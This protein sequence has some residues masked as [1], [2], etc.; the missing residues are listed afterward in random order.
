MSLS[1]SC[2]CGAGG[3]GF[4]AAITIEPDVYNEVQQ[5]IS[6]NPVSN[7]CMVLIYLYT[8]LVVLTGVQ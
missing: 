3:G 4:L 8:M 6:S 2:L 5:V 7:F 1:G